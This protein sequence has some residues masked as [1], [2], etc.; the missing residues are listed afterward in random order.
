MP[1]LPFESRRSPDSYAFTDVSIQLFQERLSKESTQ[2]HA[3][4]PKDSMGRSIEILRVLNVNTNGDITSIQT[5]ICT[6]SFS[7][8][9]WKH[10]RI[11]LTQRHATEKQILHVQKYKRVHFL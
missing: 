3:T 4:R 5:R 7:S 2:V 10:R 11:F 1:R 6:F 9:M 8:D